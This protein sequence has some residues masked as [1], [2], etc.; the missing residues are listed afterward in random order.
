MAV[1]GYAR[2]STRSQSLD[3]QIDALTAHGAERI[4][5]DQM[6][7]T[8]DDRP[9]LLA[10][11]DYLREGDVIVV[12]ALDRLGRSLL[13]ILKTVAEL[14]QRGITVRSLRENVDSSTPVGKMIMGIFGSLAEYERT[15][16]LERAEVARAAARARGK[17]TGRPKAMTAD[18][19]R[20]ARLMKDQGESVPTICQTLK[21]A[22]STLY[23]E[24]AV[25]SVGDE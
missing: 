8:R 21:V 9:Q 15:L 24:L 2:I 14:E 17:Q 16:I 10:M 11:L 3:Q 19:L 22:R 5:Q 4:F 25:A 7:G 23:R 18:Q 1:V 20:T 6:S 12:V 13:G